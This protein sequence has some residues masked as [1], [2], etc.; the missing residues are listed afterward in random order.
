[1]IM[2]EVTF[3]LEAIGAYD[4]AEARRR[5]L[6]TTQQADLESNLIPEKVKEAVYNTF[7]KD[8]KT[9]K[10]TLKEVLSLLI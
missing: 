5:R 3:A 4:K 6:T 7:K 10:N 9:Q 2:D 8:I 1:M